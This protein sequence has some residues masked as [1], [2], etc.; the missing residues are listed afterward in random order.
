MPSV[1]TGEPTADHVSRHH[2]VLGTELELRITTADPDVALAAEHAA[3]H[4]VD[5]LEAL[6]SVHRPDSALVRWRCGDSDDPGPE[7]HEVLELAERWWRRSGGVVHPATGLVTARWRRAEREGEHPG[8]DELDRL[9]VDLHVLPYSV[10]DG[11][12]HRRGDCSGVDLNA[13]AKGWIV[14]R[15][16]DTIVAVPGVEAV[17]VNAGGDLVHAGSGSATVRIDDARHAER[18]ASPRIALANAAIATSGSSHRGF[19]VG[20]A[21]FGHVL[22]PRTARPVEHVRSVSVVAPDAV[23][24]DAI[25]TAAGV[26]EADEAQRFVEHLDDVACR[27]VT[28]AGDAIVDPRWQALSRDR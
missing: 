14:D 27:I 19:R 3:L 13:I 12:L 28:S 7:V 11:R 1:A 26:M 22:D 4:T 15:I 18:A 10:V 9:A 16:R 17:V 8:D 20:T 23:T 25:A 5:R 21:W 2:P 6:L 24:A